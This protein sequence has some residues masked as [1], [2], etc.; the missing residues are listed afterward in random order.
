MHKT[1]AMTYSQTRRSVHAVQHE[2]PN[3]DPLQA[4]LAF[5]HDLAGDQVH[6]FTILREG[7]E[8]ISLT[9]I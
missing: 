3:L 7:A 6:A 4:F 5:T 8:G 1:K 9:G 2:N